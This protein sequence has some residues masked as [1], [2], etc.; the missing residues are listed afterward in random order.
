MRPLKCTCIIFLQYIQ[1][2]GLVIKAFTEQGQKGCHLLSSP[3]KPRVAH[4][5]SEC[6]VVLTGRALPEVPV[7]PICSTFNV[8][9][10]NYKRNLYSRSKPHCLAPDNFSRFVC[11][12]SP[13]PRPQPQQLPSACLRSSRML[14]LLPGMLFLHDFVWLTP[15]HLLVFPLM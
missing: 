8:F 11:S 2:K 4:T 1:G 5:S 7:I 9:P 3:L 12:Q 6:Y 14:F 13:T 15:T 10:M